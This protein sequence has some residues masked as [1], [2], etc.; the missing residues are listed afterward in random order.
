ME[1]FFKILQ[2]IIIFAEPPVKYIY[3]EDFEFQHPEKVH[4]HLQATFRY[5]LIHCY[6]LLQLISQTKEVNIK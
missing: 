4:I 2:G 3:P 1:N 5:L 6:Q